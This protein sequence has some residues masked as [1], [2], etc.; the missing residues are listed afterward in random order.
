M[1]VEAWARA[2]A[3]PWSVGRDPRIRLPPRETMRERR[4]ERWVGTSIVIVV[5]ETP[6]V[7]GSAGGRAVLDGSEEAGRGAKVWTCGDHHVSVAV[8][9]AGEGLRDPQIFKH[10]M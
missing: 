7:M 5:K 8:G 2:E 4:A 6:D 1:R 10:G 9:G 3:S